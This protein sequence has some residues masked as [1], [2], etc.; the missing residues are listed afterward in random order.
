MVAPCLHN[1]FRLWNSAEKAEKLQDI[2]PLIGIKQSRME[3]VSENDIS[4]LLHLLN[5]VPVV[6]ILIL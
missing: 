5:L 4:L 3:Q 2:S 1:Y 6:Y